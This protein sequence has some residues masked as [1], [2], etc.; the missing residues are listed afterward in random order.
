MKRK[1]KWGDGVD[2]VELLNYSQ[3]ES[4]KRHRLTVSYDDYLVHYSH[5]HRFL[6]SIKVNVIGPTFEEYVQL[7]KQF[8]G[9]SYGKLQLG[10]A[11]FKKLDKD[12]LSKVGLVNQYYE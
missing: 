4:M 5:W 1:V 8:E 11:T 6:S 7:K 9:W 12:Q 2:V 10:H 3:Q